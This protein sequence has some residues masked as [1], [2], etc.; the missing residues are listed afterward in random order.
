VDRA[1]KAVVDT[2]GDT[3]DAVADAVDSVA[4]LDTSPDFSIP[5]NSDFSNKSL[6]FSKNGVEIG[7]SCTQCFTTGA[8]DIRGRFRARQFQFEEAWIELSTEGISAKAVIGLT[9]K[10]DLT[11]TLLEKSLPIFKVSPAGVAIP[12]VLTIGPTVSVSLGAEISA[13]KG[14]VTVSCGGTAVIPPST[15]R[16]DFLDEDRTTSDGWK[17]KFKAEPFKVDA[18]IEAKA[19]AFLRAAVG[20]EISAVGTLTLARP[21]AAPR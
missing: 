6:S 17:P 18:F 10:G 13:I 1:A 14:G 9:L 15:S 16:L 7:A 5:F 11:D 8:F 20:L 3:V 19:S 4:N 12:G 2:A 21:S